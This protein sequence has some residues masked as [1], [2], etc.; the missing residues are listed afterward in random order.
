MRFKVSDN[1]LLVVFLCN[2]SILFV[3]SI[4][5]YT[6]DSTTFADS[7]ITSTT[8]TSTIPPTTAIFTTP[9]RTTTS[10]I[11]TTTTSTTYLTTTYTF[12][13]TSTTTNTN[14][15]GIYTLP[16]PS[17]SLPYGA[18]ALLYCLSTSTTIW[19]Q[20]IDNLN[21]IYVSS[22]SDPRYSVLTYKVEDG[23]LYKSFLKIEYLTQS[24]FATYTCLN[25]ASNISLTG[26]SGVTI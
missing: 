19:W 23:S 10:T 1:F 26:N 16:D 20:K 18:T 25:A 17:G 7:T 21:A 13:D 22:I 2:Y 12:T 4:T 3:H 24:D 14:F 15:A 8:A 9:T 6:T 5:T 11:P